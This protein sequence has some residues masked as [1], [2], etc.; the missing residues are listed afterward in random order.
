M[1]K[2]DEFLIDEMAHLIDNENIECSLSS[3]K[4][5]IVDLLASM[6]R[7]TNGE[8]SPD[9]VP[10]LSRLYM[11]LDDVS[12]NEDAVNAISDHYQENYS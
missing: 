5:L 9:L 8:F 1:K 12:R 11:F 7:R 2:P 6:A 10:F 3:Q 4:F